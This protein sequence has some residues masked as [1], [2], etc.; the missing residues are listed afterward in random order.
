MIN[1]DENIALFKQALIEGISRRIE[2][3][4]AEADL[5][6]PTGIVLT[7]GGD[8]LGDGTHIDA[9]GKQIE[10]CCDECNYLQICLKNNYFELR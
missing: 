9:N 7:P 8:C 1:Q 4:L 5:I 3:E 10:C 6:D 2:R